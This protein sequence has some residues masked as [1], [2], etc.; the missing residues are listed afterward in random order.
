[1]N[2][3]EF[4]TQNAAAIVLIHPSG[5]RWDYF[6]RVIPFLQEQYHLI[7]PALPGYDEAT[8]DDFPSVEQIAADLEDWL[9]SHVGSEVGCAYGCSMGGATL[10]RKLATRCINIQSAVVDGGITPYQLPYYMTRLTAIRDYVM[11]W[12]GKH[13]G[14]KLLEKAFATDDFTEEDLQCIADVL[15]RMSPKTIWRTFESCNNYPMRNTY[16][17]ITVA[18]NTGFP[19]RKKK[20]QMG[21]SLCKT[22]FPEHGIQAPSRR[23][24]RR[25]RAVQAGGFC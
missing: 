23:R 6:T 10:F 13:G 1:M 22:G 4:G 12:T 18:L 11:I 20:A 9:C 15:M 8:Q 21:Y 19:I 2:I 14:V 17:Q 25:P 7:I 5:T 24:A 3:H 16:R